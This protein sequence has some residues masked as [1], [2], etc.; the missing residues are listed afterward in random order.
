MGTY[1]ICSSTSAARH[2]PLRVSVIDTSQIKSCSHQTAQASV[3]LPFCVFRLETQSSMAAPNRWGFCC[4][5]RRSQHYCLSVYAS[6]IGVRGIRTRQTVV[7]KEIL[8]DSAVTYLRSQ[9]QK[10]T[11]VYTQ[12]NYCRSENRS[13]PSLAAR[14]SENP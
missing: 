8:V 6:L 14:A 13:R 5:K 12:K 9:F 3:R 10:G 4:A 7:I 11:G 1:F 2:K